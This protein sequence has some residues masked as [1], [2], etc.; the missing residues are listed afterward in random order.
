MHKKKFKTER[1]SL[2]A[3]TL[4]MISAYQGHAVPQDVTQED[5][6]NQTVREDSSAPPPPSACCTDTS[7][8]REPG[9]SP[10]DPYS[11]VIAADPY[12]NVIAI[13]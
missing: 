9:R 5:P 11:N 4:A 3:P 1:P 6:S 8:R 12:S 10:A 7:G 13:V 2:N